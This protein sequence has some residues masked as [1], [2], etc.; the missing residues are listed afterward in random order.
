MRRW[1]IAKMKLYVCVC[2]CV[3]ITSTK[4]ILS[5]SVYLDI[6]VYSIFLINSNIKS[7]TCININSENLDLEFWK[8]K[9]L[10]KNKFHATTINSVPNVHMN[11]CSRQVRDLVDQAKDVNLPNHLIAQISGSDTACIRLLLC[12]SSPVIKAAQ[13]SLNNKSQHGM[14][15]LTAWLPSKKEFEVNS[16]E[17]ED[18]HTD[19]SLL[20]SR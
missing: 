14:R 4:I 9:Y 2:V 11:Y 12:K 5:R 3:K 16:D 1:V 13:T 10:S 7:K 6:Y 20:P 15:Q 19:C 8:A 17:C 18:E